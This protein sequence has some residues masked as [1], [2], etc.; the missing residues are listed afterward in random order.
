MKLYRKIFKDAA[1]AS[2]RH[3]SLWLFGF[4]ATLISGVGSSGVILNRLITLDNAGE[5]TLSAFNLLGTILNVNFLTNLAKT[6]AVSPETLLVWL[7][8]LAILF[9][10][11]A[12]ITYLAVISQAGLVEAGGIL[13][14]TPAN[15]KARPQLPTLFKLFFE[16]RGNFWPVFWINVFVAISTAIASGILGIIVVNLGTLSKISIGLVFGLYWLIWVIAL[17]VNLAIYFG[18]QYAINYVVLENYSLKESLASGLELFRRNWLVSLEMALL[19]FI[20]LS[21]GLVIGTVLS[22]SAY[23]VMVLIA[24]IFASIGMKTAV[25]VTAVTLVLVLLLILLLLGAFLSTFVNLSWTFLFIR[26]TEGEAKSKLE[27]LSNGQF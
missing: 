11:A 15:K 26:L 1:V 25:I 13:D 3:K 19:I 21:V 27:R 6:V 18:G 23:F 14:S 7:V 20:L 9:L 16:N 12:A 10:I 22:I 4:F 24:N 8:V 5:Q 17:V 2:W